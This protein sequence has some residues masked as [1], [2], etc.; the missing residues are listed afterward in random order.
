MP[1]FQLT[2]LEVVNVDVF[3][4]P[5]GYNYALVAEGYGKNAGDLLLVRPRVIGSKSSGLLETKDPR[6]CPVEFE[7][8]RMDTDIFEI[9]LPAGYEIDD[10]PPPV[11]VEYSFAAYHSKSEVKDGVLRYSRTFEVRDVMVP[12][13]SWII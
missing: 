5:F 12:R 8:P 9:T 11:D 4:E 6:K 2:K 1:T 10:L 3:D 7:G 13:A